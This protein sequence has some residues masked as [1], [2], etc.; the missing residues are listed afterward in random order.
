MILLDDKKKKEQITYIILIGVLLVAVIIG[1]VIR[2]SKSVDRKDDS[3]SS[4]SE[5]MSD[6]DFE[7][8]D[9]VGNIDEDEINDD[10]Y[11]ADMEY[12][13]P[14]E[15]SHNEYEETEEETEV[16]DG[17]VEPTYIPEEN[18]FAEEQTNDMQGD[19][20]SERNLEEMTSDEYILPDSDT[21]YY[22]MKELKGLTAEEA[23]I[24]R[25]ELFARHGR[26]FDDEGLQEYFNSCSW[27][28]GTIQPDD[29][30][31]GVFNKYEIANRDLIV[32]YETKKGYR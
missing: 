20:I 13:L 3:V 26:M 21:R 22:K 12:E 31:E 10:S 6:E 16:S 17:Q 29:F 9:E 24:A 7:N 2:F 15:E 1:L 28:N 27:Y 32:K 23:R 18:V 4:I 25:N 14:T 5:D 19:E 30:D 8:I 11:N